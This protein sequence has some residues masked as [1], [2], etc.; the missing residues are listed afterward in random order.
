M[1]LFS[2]RG[3][4][5]YRR[6]LKAEKSK[7]YEMAL[8]YFSE[9]AQKDHA[10]ACFK[11]AVYYFDGLGTAQDYDK[12]LY[13]ARAALLSD[14]D[15]DIEEDIDGFIFEL[16]KKISREKKEEEAAAKKDA[17]Q[18]HE[19][20]EQQKQDEIILKSIEEFPDEKHSPNELIKK[21]FEL[22]NAGESEKALGIFLRFALAGNTQAQYNCAFIYSQGEAAKENREKVLRWMEKA[23]EQ[24]LPEAQYECGMLY[25]SSSLKKCIGWMSKAAKQTDNPEIQNKAK[26]FLDQHGIRTNP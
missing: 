4:S 26:D 20:E 15:G 17:V 21:A 22:Y 11:C 14:I 18:A 8:K 13:W 6:G 1:G 24:G 10:F 3:E 7:N 19:L 9:A 23:A 12:A 16:E 2:S 5:D 25:A